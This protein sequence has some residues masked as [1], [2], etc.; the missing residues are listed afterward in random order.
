MQQNILTPEQQFFRDIPQFSILGNDQILEIA[1]KVKK[2]KYKSGEY[3]FYQGD[4]LQELFFLEM[5]RVEI[6][7]SDINGKKL[8]LWYIEEHGIFCLADLFSPKAFASAQAIQDSMIY[9]LRKA[10]FEEIIMSSP[11][12][13]RNLICCLSSKL[14]AYSSLLDDFA[15]KKMEVRLAKILIR[16]FKSTKGHEYCCSIAQEELASMVGASREAVGR[17]LKVFRERGILT[18]SKTGRPRL[19]IAT[20]YSALEQMAKEDI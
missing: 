11:E 10:D 6:S 9:S 4:D 1:G 12:L 20:D 3:I 8:I 7:K 13:S 14:A 2:K 15:F 16:N 17:C 18:T 5:G 19:I